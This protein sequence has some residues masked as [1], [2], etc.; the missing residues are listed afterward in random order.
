MALT[1]SDL[2]TGGFYRVHLWVLMGLQTLAALAVGSTQASSLQAQSVLRDQFWL[3][4]TAATI[5]YAGAVVWMYDQ[6]KLG[7]FLLAAVAA[8]SLIACCLPAFTI[9][10]KPLAF[11][12]ADR[13]TGGL[14][15]GLVTTSMLLGHW[16]LNTPTM[17][18]APL[19]RLIIF[20]AIAVALRI[21]VCLAG[22]C[23]E[24]NQRFASSA[25]PQSWYLFLALR[26]LTGLVGTLILAALTWQTLKIPNTQSA[27][28]I[29]YAAVILTFI[30][31]LTSQLLSA[32]SLY[33]V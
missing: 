4:V 23:L 22:T 16:Y 31:E 17:K 24:A 15:L 6:R 29:L 14:C 1:P 28:G 13:V 9:S 10:A 19:R 32:E 11:Q 30:G 12:I 7:K 25:I 33:P 21:A 3:A 18:L 8:C 27:T 20:L 26:W 5:S 2:V